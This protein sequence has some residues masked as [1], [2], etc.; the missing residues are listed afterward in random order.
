MLSSVGKPAVAMHRVALKT[1]EN[2]FRCSLFAFR[3]EQQRMAND[4]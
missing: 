1:N 4:E 2:A 3:Y